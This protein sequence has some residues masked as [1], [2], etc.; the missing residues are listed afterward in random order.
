MFL[1]KS[2][3]LIPYLLSID[4]IEQEKLTAWSN[5]QISH[6]SYDC[7]AANSPTMK[8]PNIYFYYIKQKGA[9]VSCTKIA[10]TDYS[11]VAEPDIHISHP[12]VAQQSR[13]HHFNLPSI[14]ITYI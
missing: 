9:F 3:K 2:I 8:F 5:M 12:I 7:I 13:W 4:N 11:A 14:Y 10:T 6:T 1:R